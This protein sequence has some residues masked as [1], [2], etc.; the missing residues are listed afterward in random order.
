[1]FEKSGI[2]AVQ[3]AQWFNRA[4]GTPVTRQPQDEKTL[5]SVM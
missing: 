4:F 3:S 1:M 2:S 5:A